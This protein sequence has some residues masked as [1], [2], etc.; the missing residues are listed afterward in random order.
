MNVYK[1]TTQQNNLNFTPLFEE[2]EEEEEAKNALSQLKMSR[3]NHK[4]RVRMSVS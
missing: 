1:L 2:E 3:C 4:S